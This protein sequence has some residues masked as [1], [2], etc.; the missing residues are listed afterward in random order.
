MAPIIIVVVIAAICGVGLTL[1]AKFMSVPVDETA[2]AIRA[3]LPGANCGACGFAG[4]DEYAEKLSGG[5]VKANLCIP[6]G[7]GVGQ[8][9]SKLLGVNF[10][11]VVEMYAVVRCSG[12]CEHTTYVMDYQGPKSC[13]GCNFFFQGR[14]TCSH[15]CL[16]YGDCVSKCQYGALTIENGIAVV[17]PLLCTGCG[18]C[19]SS[20][21]NHLITVIPQ[22]SKIFVGCH[23]TDK[24]A[25]TRKLCS[26][27]CIGCKRCE[28]A[29]EHG[30]IV[31]ENNLARIDPDKCV[32]CGKC[33]GVCPT[34]VVHTVCVSDGTVQAPAAEKSA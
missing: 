27:G 31:I 2:A 25:F 24:G 19:V 14:G 12:T 3:E 1:A 23:S 5:G 16:G 26:A 32:N 20:C 15:A 10:E 6:G 33:I 22:T 11:D 29:C 9:I 7:D 17:D 4:C 8:K 30:A 34:K 13:E 28:K 21:P 18:M